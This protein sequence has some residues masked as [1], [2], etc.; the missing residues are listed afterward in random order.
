MMTQECNIEDRQDG[1]SRIE[2]KGNVGN[3]WL[4]EKKKKGQLFLFWQW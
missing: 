4:R 1:A 2:K 3:D